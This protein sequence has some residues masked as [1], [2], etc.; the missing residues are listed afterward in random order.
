M[1]SLD[2]DTR[3]DIY[4][5]GVLLYELI[6]GRTPFDQGELL[7]VGLDEM[8]RT[9]RDKEPPKPSTRLRT[10]LEADLTTTARC[11]QMEPPRLI[12]SVRGD[13]DWIVMK[14]L[15]KDRARR[16]ETASGL[17]LDVQRHLCN[18]PVS[19]R[20]PSNLPVAKIGSA[21]SP[22][23]CR[24]GCGRRRARAGTGHSWGQQRPDYAREKSARGCPESQGRGV[25]GGAHERAARA[26]GTLRVIAQPGPGA[27]LQPAN[28]SAAGQ[29]GGSG[30]GRPHSS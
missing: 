14:A 10:L 16:Y 9:I 26:R 1:T 17:A 19:A 24:C 25:D 30:R 20:S 11:R 18:E 21:K 8:R 3:G 22:C 7:A 5:L 23:I 13:L 29:P 4:S 15:E 6:T 2:V 28:G 27:A 12:H